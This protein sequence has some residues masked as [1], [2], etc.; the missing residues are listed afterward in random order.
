M[1]SRKTVRMRGGSDRIPHRVVCRWKRCP[2]PFRRKRIPLSR[3]VV[4]RYGKHDACPSIVHH[5]HM[6]I[7]KPDV[8]SCGE[9]RILVRSVIFW[10]AVVRSESDYNDTDTIFSGAV[11]SGISTR[12]LM[13]NFFQRLVRRCFLTIMC[14]AAGVAEQNKRRTVSV[15]IGPSGIGEKV[16]P[17]AGDSTVAKICGV[18]S[19]SRKESS[20]GSFQ[21]SSSPSPRSK[22]FNFNPSSSPNPFRSFTFTDEPEMPDTHPR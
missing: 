18:S 19:F 8:D 13:S 2:R 14:V 11:I 21:S 16:M 4:L 17:S 10:L 15:R 9:R 12:T 1:Y 5:S 3:Q 20:S 7:S 22:H 6:L